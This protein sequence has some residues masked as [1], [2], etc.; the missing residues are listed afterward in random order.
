[1]LGAEDLG[2][3]GKKIVRD[4]SAY[5]VGLDS[6]FMQITWLMI[7]IDCYLVIIHK[8]EHRDDSE[9]F[10]SHQAGWNSKYYSSSLLPDP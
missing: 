7:N 5:F 2:I 1:L 9:I 10:A 6:R 4:S 3:L 8:N